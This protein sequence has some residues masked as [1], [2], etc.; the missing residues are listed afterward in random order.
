MNARSLFSNSNREEL[1]DPENA[2]KDSC[3]E[4]MPSPAANASDDIGSKLLLVAVI[5][6]E[7]VN[8]GDTVD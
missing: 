2:D 5:D 6:N 1:Y 7:R 8:A 3:S 4:P